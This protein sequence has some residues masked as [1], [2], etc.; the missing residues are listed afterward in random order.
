MNRYEELKEQSNKIISG[1]PKEPY[2]Y[3]NETEAWIIDIT[4]FIDVLL[5]HIKKLEKE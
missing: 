5:D 2:E 3:D 1:L 4:N